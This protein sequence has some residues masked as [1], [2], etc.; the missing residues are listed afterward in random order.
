MAGDSS[1]FA[2]EDFSIDAVEQSAFRIH[3]ILR[4]IYQAIE[5]LRKLKTL[6]GVEPD[7]GTEGDSQSAQAKARG[8]CYLD[9][10]LRFRDLAA[11]CEGKR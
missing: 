9:L 7:L 3:T 11:R 1:R 6:S 10:E 5:V 2:F 8:E 4:E